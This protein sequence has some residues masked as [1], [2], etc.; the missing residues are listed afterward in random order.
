VRAEA[1]QLLDATRFTGY[2]EV[3]KWFRLRNSVLFVTDL[4]HLFMNEQSNS[5]I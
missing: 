4:R 3:L 2:C 5:F 1:N